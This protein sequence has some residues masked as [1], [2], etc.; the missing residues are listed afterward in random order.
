MS[1]L[2]GLHR[3]WSLTTEYER[4][5]HR[6]K[7]ESI[8]SPVQ[9]KRFQWNG[10]RGSVQSFE[11]HFCFAQ[12]THSKATKENACT[13]VAAHFC[14]VALHL[15]DSTVIGLSQAALPHKSHECKHR[16]HTY[17]V[18]NL[19]KALLLHT[20]GLPSLALSP[21]RSRGTEMLQARQMWA[22]MHSYLSLIQV[23]Q[24]N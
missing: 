9:L 15:H 22:D 8:T 14:N 19:F 18:D 20:E 6:R 5:R 21:P 23:F 16:W 13:L 3:Y 1:S 17:F 12:T 2:L 10:V 11:N 4:F 24:M 7:D